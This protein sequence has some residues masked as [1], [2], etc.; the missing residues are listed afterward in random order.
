MIWGLVVVAVG[1]TLGAWLVWR[2]KRSDA[3]PDSAPDG[4]VEDPRL[5]FEELEGDHRRLLDRLREPDLTPADREQLE[6]ATARVLRRIDLLERQGVTVSGEAMPPVEESSSS[7]TPEQAMSGRRPT[8]I[9]FAWGVAV[10][11]AVTVLIMLAGGDS[12]ER[13]EGE[14]ITGGDSLRP[15]VDVPSNFEHPGGE[16]PPEIQQQLD[17]LERR[18]T[19]TQDLE[20]LKELTLA[21]LALK[22]FMQTHRWSQVLLEQDPDDPDGQYAQGVVRM[23]MG[24]TDAAIQHFDRVLTGF[25]NHLLALVAKGAAQRGAGRIDAARDTWQQA[26]MVSGGQAQIQQLLDELDRPAGASPPQAAMPAAGVEVDSAASYRVELTCAGNRPD[27][28]T[29]FVILRGSQDTG[30]GGPPIAVRRLDNPTLPVTL[31]LSQA[32]SMIGAQLPEE[33]TLVARWDA[34]GNALTREEL[35]EVEVKASLDAT[36]ALNVCS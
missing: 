13:R 35:P 4:G 28:T 3:R 6:L 23:A 30:R 20:A 15:G 10:T 31:T 25:P 36:T 24:Q 26:L 8:W 19:A 16:V 17:D 9:G 7:Q 11:L 32:D 12:R 22:R 5:E 2:E 1:V 29:L 34:D 14:P 27:A 33:A 18:W 21:N